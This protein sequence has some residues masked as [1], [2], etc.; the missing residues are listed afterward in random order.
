M[1]PD[2][3]L[4]Y[5]RTFAVHVG[6]DTGKK[7]HVMVA[8]GPDG[9][10][11]SPIRVEVTRSSFEASLERLY[12][13]FP[14]VPPDR[15]L[16]GVEFAGHHGFTYA[17]FL[18]AQGHRVVSVLPAHTKR[19]KEL[20]DNSPNKSDEIDAALISRLT[21]EGRFV[22]FPFLDEAMARLKLLVVQR[23]RLTVE[24]GR[25][26]NR[27]QGMLD[28]AWPELAGAFSSID[29][30]TP[31]AILRRW[32]LPQ[33]LAAASTRTVRHLIRKTSR[34]QISAER[35]RALVEAARH[36]IGLTQAPEGRRI[37]IRHLFARWELALEQMAALDALME[38]LVM[39]C[40][41][42]RSL[43]TVPEVSMVCAAT[44]VTEMGNP[45][46]YEHPRQILKLAGMNLVAKVSGISVD[47][48]RWQSKRG[49]PMLRRQLFLLAG[50]WCHSR[51]LY[52]Q[53][54][55]RMLE[56]N[57]KRRKKAVAA[58]SRKLVPLLFHVMKTG[59]PFDRERFLSNR[60]SP[61]VPV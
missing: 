6:V 53:D 13:Q 19:A 28:L 31:L 57:G 5:A 61:E 2:E 46:A 45:S 36:T 42:A 47:G 38:P 14:D 39:G 55:L 30:R 9:V 18:R 56:R 34:G 15:Y 25:F 51:G 12:A 26:K 49:R 60:R 17:H 27:L 44:I 21:G 8:R 22:P 7:H 29:K 58:F 40:H 48:R 11:G 32:P 20:D 54:Y 37:E 35:T 1:R 59:E 16:V 23:H 4:V 24:A 43:L 41:E 3:K 52:R 10:A 33:D 50:R